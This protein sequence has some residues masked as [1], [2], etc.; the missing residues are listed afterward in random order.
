[1]TLDVSGIYAEVVS[2]AERLGV[3]NQVL[4]HEPKAAPGDGLTCAIWL[5]DL[6]TVP[7]VS[8]LDVTSV[9]LEL[10]IRIYENF[11]SQPEDAIDKRLLDATSKLFD[12]YNG[13]IQLGG[14]AMEI[15]IFGAYGE[16]LR[17]RGGYLL[18]GTT[19]Y[20]VVVITLPII[21]ADQYTQSD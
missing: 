12:S 19:Q 7:D 6:E 10:A 15:D 16:K 9:R 8:G 14:T 13:D 1:M 18:S 17:A 20:R 21:I 5:N 3:F 11:L 4:T 2:H